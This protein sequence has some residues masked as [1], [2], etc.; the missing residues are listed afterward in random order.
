MVGAVVMPWPI[1][2]S[3]PDP[4]CRTGCPNTHRVDSNRQQA[5]PD[6]GQVDHSHRN[7]S[8][9]DHPHRHH[10]N[11]DDAHRDNADGNRSQWSN[12]HSKTLGLTPQCAGEESGVED[13]VMG[14]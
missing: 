14:A 13:S 5:H 7:H 8:D 12:P 6:D 1:P 4:C 9:G 3:E 2:P 11:A 10:T